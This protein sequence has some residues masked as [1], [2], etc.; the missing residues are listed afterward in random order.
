MV[1]KKIIIDFNQ[2]PE[3]L[4]AFKY[5]IYIGGVLLSYGSGLN[6]IDLKYRV[7]GNSNPY[8][9]GIGVDLSATID[10]TL[11]FLIGQYHFSGSVGGFATSIAYSKVGNTIEVAI[12][13]AAVEQT[14]TFWEIVS[15]NPFI[16]LRPENPCSSAYISNQTVQA[17]E[18][19]NALPSN[20]Y[21]LRNNTL[22]IDTSS[23][24]PNNLNTRL[25][26]GYNY[27]IIKG[28]D[29]TIKATF[30]IPA[31]ITAAN[32]DI[33]FNNND[34]FITINGASPLLGFR[35]SIDDITYQDDAVFLALAEG[36]YTVYIQDSYGCKKSFL[37]TNT[38]TTNGNITVPYADISESN[39]LRFA[40][41][42]DWG[43]CGNYKNVFN[44][45]SCEENTPVKPN[46][47]TQLFQACDTN[48][49]TQVRTS[50]ENVEVAA[51]NT[52]ITANKIVAYIGVRD[53][54]D[55]TYYSYNN[56]LAILFTSGN[57][58]DYGTATVNGTYALN[59]LLPDYGIVGNYVET[60]YGTLQIANIRLDDNGQR[61]LIFNVAITIIGTIAG[62]AQTIYNQESYDIWEFNIDMSAFLNTSF[63]VGV[64]FYQTVAD[65]NFPDIIYK[66]EKI[67]V[68][69]RWEN[70][71]E[72][73]WRNSEN[74]DIYFFSG[75]EMKNRLNFCEINTNL[76]DGDV[77][78]EKT[79]SAII[80]IDASNYNLLE[81]EANFLTTG[82]M[83]KIKLALIHDYLIIEG[84]P[85]VASEKPE[86][87]R[88]GK[89]NFYNLKAKVYEAGD[90]WN[91]GTA[92]TQTIFTTVP[93]IGLLQGDAD[94]EYLRI[95]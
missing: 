16:L 70:S 59:G 56:Q 79:D 30:D 46:I 54:R 48:I 11:A 38:G 71:K 5:T 64:R 45:L 83:R 72:I 22:N 78:V 50:Y 2:Q 28:S 20:F 61:S 53:K 10:N 42:V 33:Y 57:T 23:F 17:W 47:F 1:T 87:E 88:L 80:P 18:E 8:E 68:K 84:V 82:M 9:I 91:Q 40:R 25:D 24:I 62:T 21:Y 92:N 49:K 58:Y 44:T 37:I 52:S 36:D 3:A 41:R 26:R 81:F 93:L 51:G 14:V 66:S 19:I 85:Y 12:T 35:Y 95:Q 27:S 63:N 90:V 86:T 43:N 75:I 65:P 76:S 69:T 74:T 55:C 6:K 13:S 77:E 39:S 73:I 94:A 89:S 15:T 32:T 4:T 7:G 31:S 67:Q 29:G 60:A 34:L